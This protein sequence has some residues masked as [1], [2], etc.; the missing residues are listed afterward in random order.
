MCPSQNV[1]ISSGP[2]PILLPGLLRGST[3][4]TLLEHKASGSLPAPKAL[5][6]QVQTC[7]SSSWTCVGHIS[8]APFWNIPN[9]HQPPQTLAKLCSCSFPVQNEAVHSVDF[10]YRRCQ[11]SR[12]AGLE[13]NKMRQITYSLLVLF[14]TLSKSVHKMKPNIFSCY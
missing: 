12:K 9:S 5:A 13:R 14:H 4:Q 2:C 3:C 7:P 11:D 10:I 1:C 6:F 8:S